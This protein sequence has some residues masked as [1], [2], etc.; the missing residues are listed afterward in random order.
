MSNMNQLKQRIKILQSTVR[1]LIQDIPELSDK[2]ELLEKWST[3]RCRA[4][5]L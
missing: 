3:L 4:Q 1:E 2:L 5:L